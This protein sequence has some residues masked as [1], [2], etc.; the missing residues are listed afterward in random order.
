MSFLLSDK[1]ISLLSQTFNS[2]TQV[3]K[4]VELVIEGVLNINN[5]K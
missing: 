5:Q 2:E 3:E 1:R 4:K